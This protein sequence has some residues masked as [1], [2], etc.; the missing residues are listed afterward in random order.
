M[1]IR[2]R[3]KITTSAT[4]AKVDKITAIATVANIATT[5]KFTAIP[6]NDVIVKIAAPWPVWFGLKGHSEG[7]IA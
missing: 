6:E 4:L 2:S 5:P 3:T 1:K 7:H